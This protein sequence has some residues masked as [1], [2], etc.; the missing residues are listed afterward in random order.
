MRDIKWQVGK[1]ST[2][3]GFVS[4]KATCN[5]SCDQNAG[6]KV[7]KELEEPVLYPIEAFNCF[8][9]LT[10]KVE[11]SFGSLITSLLMLDPFGNLFQL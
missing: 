1:K 8:P 3:F 6:L 9:T 11:D 7:R 10:A 2:N 5:Q 4:S